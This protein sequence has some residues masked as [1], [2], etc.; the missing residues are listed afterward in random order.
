MSFLCS[1]SSQLVLYNTCGTYSTCAL[2]AAGLWHIDSVA[3]QTR[4]SDEQV[5]KLTR[6]SAQG[7]TCLH[8]VVKVLRHAR[9]SCF[10][11]HERL[12]VLFYS[13]FCTEYRSGHAVRR[14]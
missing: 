1:N 8:L 4:G 6:S 11:L 14:L 12:L 9:T 10:V 7:H 3:A 2:Q 5:H 13:R